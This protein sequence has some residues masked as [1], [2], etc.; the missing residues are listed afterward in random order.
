MLISDAWA[1]V[2]PPNKIAHTPDLSDD[3]VELF[4]AVRDV[5]ESSTMR[6]SLPVLLVSAQRDPVLSSLHTEF[7]RSR[8]Q[9]IIERLR[10]SV[11]QGQ[12][13]ADTDPELM[14]DLLSGAVFY[15]QLLRR[16]PTSD[17]DVR[18][19]VATVLAGVTPPP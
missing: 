10:V 14:V 19:I 1:Q 15:R 17:D 4:L 18:A 13:V 2:S 9:P 3:L 16:E 7:V 6:R 11:A 5:V 8:R 12:L